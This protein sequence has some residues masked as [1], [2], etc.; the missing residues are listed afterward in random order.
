MKRPTLAKPKPV[1][2][3]PAQPQ[4]QEVEEEKSDHNENAWLDVIANPKVLAIICFAVSVGIYSNTLF[5]EFTFDDFAAIATN[6]FVTGDKPWSDLFRVDFWGTPTTSSLS[7]KSYRPLTSFLYRILYTFAG[8]NAP[9]FHATAILGNALVSA[10]AVLLVLGPVVEDSLVRIIAALLYAVH[11]VKTEA[12]SGIVGTAEII[13]AAMGFVAFHFFVKRNSP[14]LAGLFCFFASIA[15]ETGV[16]ISLILAVYSL[17]MHKKPQIVPAIL[18]VGTAFSLWVAIRLYVFT[19]GWTIEPS[20]QDNPMMMKKGL[21]WL[22]NTAVVQT[23]YLEILFWP[24][25]LTCDYSFNAMPLA[26]KIFEPVVGLAA[27]A[28]ALVTWIVW[29][30]LTDKRILFAASWYVAPMLPATHFLGVIGTLVAERLLYVPLLG[31]AILMGEGAKRVSKGSKPLK[32]AVL[33]LAV[34]GCGALGYR[35]IT[36]NRDW[37]SNEVLFHET[38]KVVPNSIK[39]VMNLAGLYFSKTDAANTR[40]YCERA[41]KIDPTY[42]AALQ[43]QGRAY[44]DIERDYIKARQTLTSCLECMLPQRHSSQ[45]LSE[46]YEMLGTSCLNLKDYDESYKHFQKSVSIGNKDAYCNMA[47]LLQLQKKTKEALEPSELCVKMAMQNYR[48]A[49][50]FTRKQAAIK[51]RNHGIL[52]Y[53]L[54]RF[55]EALQSMEVALQLDPD[56]RSQ[57]DAYIQE[58]KKQMPGA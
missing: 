20:P 23:K 47:V 22:V 16:T 9:V 7:H 30:S 31:W 43:L 25:N 13:S 37:K 36:R 56:D 49:N 46:V 57:A 29:K 6:P 10:L 11:P 34:V 1:F 28:T 55:K 4:V 54:D 38:A 17:R 51:N 48:L 58:I 24:N 18:V 12:V 5:H 3:R 27:L 52:L 50:P 14:I 39:A 15:K 35:T 40:R 42:C 45:L 44:L 33:A 53:H 32:I 26:S 2:P 19:S 8:N 41:L 21:M